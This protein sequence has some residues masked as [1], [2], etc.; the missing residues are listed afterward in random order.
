MAL[1]VRLRLPDQWYAYGA[2]VLFVL[3]PD[4]NLVRFVLIAHHTD[5]LIVQEGIDPYRKDEVVGVVRYEYEA[6]TSSFRKALTR[7]AKMAS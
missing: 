4:Q 5:H 6:T 7:T 1:A 2:C 3:R